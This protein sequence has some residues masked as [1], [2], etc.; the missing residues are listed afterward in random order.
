MKRASG[1]RSRRSPSRAAAEA[2]K[3]LDK[4]ISP[5]NSKKLNELADE[6]GCSVDHVVDTLIKSYKAGAKKRSL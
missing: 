4:N 1:S 6:A 5:K 2:P 3:V